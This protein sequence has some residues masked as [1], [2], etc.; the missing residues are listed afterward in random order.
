MYFKRALLG[1]AAAK[2]AV[3]TCGHP[4]AAPTHK[5]KPTA[6]VRHGHI[7]FQVAWAICRTPI[8]YPNPPQN[9]TVLSAPAPANG[10]QRQQPRLWRPSAYAVMLPHTPSS[11]ATTAVEVRPP[12]SS[13][14]PPVECQ[15]C[16]FVE[17]CVAAASLLLRLPQRCS[18]QQRSSR[19]MG[20]EAPAPFLPRHRRRCHG[21]PSSV[22]AL[23]R[24][25]SVLC[26]ACRHSRAMPTFY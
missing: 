1:A 14:Q 13:V 6:A 15:R 26:G 11:P 7:S 22:R 21:S 23:T 3:Q 18:R 19:R 10:W 16:H 25:V 8:P 20:A 2:A 5:Y 9:L 17:L 24:A 12:I 4:V